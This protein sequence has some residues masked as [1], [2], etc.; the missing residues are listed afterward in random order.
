MSGDTKLPDALAV[1]SEVYEHGEQR[2]AQF[3]R[4]IKFHDLE[5]LWTWRVAL[6]GIVSAARQLL[7][8][9]DTGIAEELGEGGAVVF[10]GKLI[11]F[12]QSGSWK[13]IDAEAL[14]EFLGEDARHCFRPEDIRITSLRA[15]ATK[16][17]RDPRVIVDSLMDYEK[18]DPKV[19]VMPVNSTKAPKYAATMKPGEIRKGKP[20][21]APATQGRL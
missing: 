9:V 11:R 5:T 14:W 15:I 1:V 17:E 20:K 13:A 2:A 21:K 4:N 19:E 10:D 12:K 7:A 8:E 16:R 18:G 6:A 3:G